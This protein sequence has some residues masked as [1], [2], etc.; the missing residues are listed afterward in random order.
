[1]LTVVFVGG[2]LLI[3]QNIPPPIS[4]SPTPSVQPSSVPKGTQIV[5]GDKTYTYFL[6]EIKEPANLTLIPNFVEKK[7]SLSLFEENHCLFGINGGFYTQANK[8]LGVFFAN[9]NYIVKTPHERSFFNG[10]VYKKNNKLIISQ[11]LPESEGLDF[12]FQSGPLLYPN[13]VLRSEN[14]F[15]ARRMV[16]IEIVGN[17]LY[18]VTL[19]GADNIHDGPLLSEVPQILD[20]MPFPIQKGINLDGGAAS[21]FITKD[22]TLGEIN[23]VGS[24]LCQK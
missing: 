12:L 13:Q 15:P 7:T 3:N 8:P 21:A 5:L 6:Y 11:T 9:H 10:F 24:F 18:G 19:T 17:K 1:M 2:F 14:D 4:I 22:L 16:L 20:Q 23:P